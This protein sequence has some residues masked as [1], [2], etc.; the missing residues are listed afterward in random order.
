MK[1]EKPRVLMV[2]D[3][4]NALAGYRRALGRRYAVTTAESGPEA[5]ETMAAEKTFPVVITDMRMP[6]MDGLMFLRAAQ[7]IWSDT[8]YVML[9]GN[10]DQKTATD[11]INE[12]QV[13]RFL[14][15]PCAAHD[16]ERTIDAAARQYE[17]VTAERV[18]LQD[19]LSGSVR[20]LVE[21]MMLSDPHLG[22]AASGVS[23]EMKML[24]RKLGIGADWRL[25]LAG[26]LCLM[27]HVVVADTQHRHFL[28][29]D[30]LLASAE[31]GSRLLRHIPRLEESAQMV[32]RQREGGPL[33]E[34]LELNGDARRVVIGARLLRF[35]VDFYREVADQGGD[36]AAAIRRLAAVPDKYDPRLLAAA[37]PET[38][39]EGEPV[40]V[41]SPESVE[42]DIVA[43]RSGMVLDQDVCTHD[44]KLLLSRGY[45]LNATVLERLRSFAKSRRI[46][47]DLRV[48]VT[49]EASRDQR[50]TDAGKDDA[51]DDV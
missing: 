23:D 18:L 2:D 30:F 17:L 27:G 40:P 29:H 32:A 47:R 7:K 51:A 15:K 25:S 6:G 38:D 19:T 21:A 35:A 34:S 1:I 3:A 4:P 16:L 28:S 41:G 14:N 20:M 13:F 37:A 33:P 39:A 12:G 49:P 22:R 10:A 11:A 36:R 48:L 42:L 31:S 24:M 43:V 26:S 50:V 5:L 46:E 9:T 8:V 44:G 45:V